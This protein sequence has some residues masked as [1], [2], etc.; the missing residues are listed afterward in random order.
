M[1][2][3]GPYEQP[4]QPNQPQPSGGNL[5]PVN[6]AWP[7]S[8]P[9]VQPLQPA[10][11]PQQ[12]V[13]YG[14]QY[15]QQQFDQPFENQPGNA[16]PAVDYMGGP[17]D[18]MRQE[19]SIDYLNKIAPQQQ[20]TV[21]RFAVFGL[22]GAVIFSAIF[23]VMLMSNSG[24]PSANSQLLPVSERITT[25]QTVSAAQQTEL[26]EVQIAEANA[27]L[28]SALTSMSTDMGKLLTARK[29]KTGTKAQVATETAYAASL[30][31]T[32]SDAYQ[33]GT[34]DRTYTTQMTYELS[35][36][37]GKL[38]KLKQGSKAKDITDFCDS[39]IANIDTVL[40]AYS[41]FNATK[42]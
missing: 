28:S 31:K 34:L 10:Q 2:P 6:S 26:N 14:A 32:L 41:S 7:G 29:L 3:N 22:I 13:S 18:Q 40:K 30:S 39:G 25:L 21:N 23:A 37:R 19:Y 33:R 9:Q 38:T 4:S 11:P 27:A 1:N 8:A 24:A 42:S 15:A 20:K 35:V 16:Q 12:P 17:S 5:P 36:L